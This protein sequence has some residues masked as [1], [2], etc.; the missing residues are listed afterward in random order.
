MAPTC[1]GAR[2]ALDDTPMGMTSSSEMAAVLATT[3]ASFAVVS[4]RGSWTIFGRDEKYL[5]DGL[6]SEVEVAERI[7]SPGKIGPQ[8]QQLLLDAVRLLDLRGAENR[9]GV[10]VGIQIT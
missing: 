3:A 10:V 7:E 8:Q 1:S 2:V 5:D 6:G 4:A 9:F